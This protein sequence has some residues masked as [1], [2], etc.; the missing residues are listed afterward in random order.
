MIPRLIY[1]I[2]NKRY[3]RDL[4]MRWMLSTSPENVRLFLRR[5]MG[6]A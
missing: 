6:L 5:R 1:R 3:S 4:F 2:R